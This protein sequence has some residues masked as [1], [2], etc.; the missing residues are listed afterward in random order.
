MKMRTTKLVSGILMI[1]LSVFITFQS[2]IAGLGNALDGNGETGGSGGVL[3]AIIFLATGIV[4]IATKSKEKLTADVINMVLLLIAWLLA[5]SNA[6]SYSDLVI[7]GW[8][9]FI[10]GVGFFVWHYFINQK[11][12]NAQRVQ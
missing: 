7:W 3:T 5:I 6:G 8:L 2:T 11:S 1:I 4:Y 9:A 12:K 10:I